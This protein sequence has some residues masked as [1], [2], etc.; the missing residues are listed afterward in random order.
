MLWEIVQKWWKATFKFKIDISILDI[1]FGLPN[2]NKENLNHLYNYVILYAKHFI[3]NNKKK[4]K[5]L[6][7]HEFLLTIKQELKYNKE[8]LTELNQMNKINKF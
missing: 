8:T 5:P 4:A 3:Y 2:E 7:L 1:I 6:H